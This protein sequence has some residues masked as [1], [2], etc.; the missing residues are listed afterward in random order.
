MI[1]ST[2][3][4]WTRLALGVL[5]ILLLAVSC[6]CHHRHPIDITWIGHPGYKAID[7][8]TFPLK[9]QV[10]VWRNPDS[11]KEQ[12]NRWLSD[13]KREDTGVHALAVCSHCDTD[14]I[15]LYQDTL[16]SHLQSQTVGSPGGQPSP[17]PSGGNGPALYSPNYRT[18]NHDSTRGTFATLPKGFDTSYTWPKPI[19]SGVLTVAVFDSGLDSAGAGVVATVGGSCFDA[20]GGMSTAHGWNFVNNNANTQDDMADKHGTKV[21]K[22]ILN[23]VRKYGGAAT[24]NGSIN[25]DILPVKIFD[26]N[27][28]GTLFATLCALAYVSGTGAKIVNAS[29][30]FYHYADNDTASSLKAEKMLGSFISQYLNSAGMLLV[31]AAGND[32]PAEDAIFNSMSHGTAY[33]YLDSNRFYPAV[34]AKTY[35]NIIAVTTVSNRT[36]KPSPLENASNRSVDIGT[37]CDII[38]PDGSYVFIDPITRPQQTPNGYLVPTI[39]GS[40]FAAPIVT[41]RI[42]AFYSKLTNKTDKHSI[43]PAM[44]TTL[45]G[46]QLLTI[47]QALA[48][49]IVRGELAP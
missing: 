22:L 34:F 10:V 26:S 32:D 29:F 37:Q 20:P 47:D 18:S 45:N 30:G 41:G 40:S 42:A 8:N 3:F 19:P 39:T 36:Q 9:N 1:A 15:L 43:I 49:S 14:V 38:A 48:D 6:D 46:R 4:G 35:P 27:G 28:Q 44:N 16:L 17:G 21:T 23:Q 2:R 25:V 11:S 5:T 24:A 33:R 12:F 13:L 7:T 31:A